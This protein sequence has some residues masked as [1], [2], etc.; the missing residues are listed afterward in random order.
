MQTLKNY[1]AGR[2]I[3]FFRVKTGSSLG[4]RSLLPAFL[5]RGLSGQ[6]EK[7]VECDQINGIP[8]P[9]IWVWK[10]VRLEFQVM[11]TPGILLI[12]GKVTEMECWPLPHRSRQ[13]AARWCLKLCNCDVNLYLDFLFPGPCN[14]GGWVKL[15]P[16]LYCPLKDKEELN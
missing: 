6:N 3:N 9:F 13:A 14:F 5:G 16:D 7:S 15:Q 1:V 2:Q 12:E 4:K 10:S 8:C 11:K